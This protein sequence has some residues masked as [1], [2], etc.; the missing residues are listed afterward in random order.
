MRLYELFHLAKRRYVVAIRYYGLLL[1]LTLLQLTACSTGPKLPPLPADGVILAF[2]DSLTYGTGAAVNQSYPVLLSVMINRQVVNAG[3]PGETTA[4]GLARL[5]GTLEQI[6]PS[7]VILCLGA[8]DM[9]RGLDQK[10]AAENLK[11]MLEMIRAHG[12]AAVMIAVPS[13]DFAP[14]PPPNYLEIAEQA[15]VPCERKSLAHILKKN[16]LRSD[17]VH[18]NGAGYRLITEALADLLKRSGAVP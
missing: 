5:P 11:A 1:G 8:N 7:L 4:E 2:G 3:I 16:S 15:G 6:K 10:R 9:M 13:F 14:A 18:P 12:A 17:I